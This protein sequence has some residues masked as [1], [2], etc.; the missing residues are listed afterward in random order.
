M[1]KYFFMFLI[2]LLLIWCNSQET[3]STNKMKASSTQKTFTDIG[4]IYLE[5]EGFMQCS[6]QAVDQCMISSLWPDQKMSMEICDD[7]L[8]AS[9]RESCKQSIVIASAR[10]WWDI[11]ACDTLDEP[12]ICRYELLLTQGISREDASL[13][14]SLSWDLKIQCNN[15]VLRSLA[16]SQ[17]NVEICDGIIVRVEDDK[18][19][20]SEIDICKQEVILEDEMKQQAIIAEQQ[21]QENTQIDEIEPIPEIIEE[22]TAEE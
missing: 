6:R 14:S 22:A 15:N 20:E 4:R 13:C 5:D 11:S 10:E 1:K 16:R 9:N 21:E 17:W 19:L 12:Q 3:G 8:L 2:P 7:M 18:V